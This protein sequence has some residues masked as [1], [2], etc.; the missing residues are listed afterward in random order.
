M[1]KQ[2]HLNHLREYLTEIRATLARLQEALAATTARRPLEIR[3]RQDLAIDVRATTAYLHALEGKIADIESGTEGPWTAER[4]SIAMQLERPRSTLESAPPWRGGRE[5][6]RTPLPHA[7][8]STML[9]IG[10]RRISRLP[11][12]NDNGGKRG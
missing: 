11:T 1:D 12:D 9:G 6:I 8:R 4:F 3:T 5:T 2:T 10:C 7:E